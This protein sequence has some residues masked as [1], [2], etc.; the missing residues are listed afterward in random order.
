MKHSLNTRLL[1]LILTLAL[2]MMLSVCAAVAEDVSYPVEGDL[3]LTLVRRADPDLPTVG[4]SSYNESPGVKA[5]IEQTGIALDVIE[6]ADDN[7]L[8]VYLASGNL[9]DIVIMNIR[10]AYPG[11]VGGMVADGIASD[12]T[13]DLPR[14]AP[15]YWAFIN[16]NPAYLSIAREPDGHYYG[17]PGTIYPD[18][19]PYRHWFGLVARKEYLDQL[20]MEAPTTADEIYTFL[21]RCKEEL[22]VETPFMADEFRLRHMFDYDGSLSSPFGLVM[23]GR[24]VKDGTVHYGQYEPEFKEMLIWLN[25]LH[26]EGLF[27]PNFTLTDEPTAH[28]AILSGKSA[29]MVTAASRVANLMKSAD[30]DDF[31]LL[32]LSSLQQ[33]DGSQAFYCF[34]ST[35]VEGSFTAF[36]PESTSPEKRIAALKLLNYLFTENGHMLTNFGVEGET[37]EMVDG[38]PTL[39]EFM[40]NNPDGK[41]LDGMLRAYAMLNWPMW[42]EPG[43]LEQRYAM[44]EQR[45]SIEAWA[46]ADTD[47]YQIQ[48]TS[49]APE[50]VDEYARLWTDIDTYIKEYRAQFIAGSKAPDT[51]ESEYL[52]TLQQMG[53]DR[54]LEIYQL[55]YDMYNK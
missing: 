1:A 47:I 8:K 24:Y 30:A 14:Y 49:I 38:V 45:Q 46:E 26:T 50:F 16:S 22:G 11:D 19:S 5:L 12:L 20:G 31:T 54:V 13:D 35:Y 7:A 34:A 37:Y 21:K 39:T 3:K 51:F 44:P 15:D 2:S 33:A 28:A 55:S 23:T 32:G 53:M 42:Y 6:P 9:A 29:L 18:G 4:I 10:N 27:D 40:T 43:L 48:N 17:I 25:K 52:P 36:I 41:P